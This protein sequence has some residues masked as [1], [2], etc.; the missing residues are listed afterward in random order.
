MYLKFYAYKINS[1]LFDGHL[2][3]DINIGSICIP[4][5]PDVII[6]MFQLVNFK[7]FVLICGITKTNIGVETEII[8]EPIQQT[9][10]WPGYKTPTIIFADKDV[11]ISALLTVLCTKP[12]TSIR[13][14]L[15]TAFKVIMGI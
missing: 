6:N 4:E 7:G 8:A 10:F 11:I 1:H 5:Y 12:N 3:S 2:S 14:H 13:L 15:V 9:C